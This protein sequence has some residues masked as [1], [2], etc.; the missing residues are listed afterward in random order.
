ML[1]AESGIGKPDVELGLGLVQGEAKGEERDKPMEEG[2]LR[3]QTGG[4]GL[5]RLGGGEQLSILVSRRACSDETRMRVLAGRE[6]GGG[7][8]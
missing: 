4:G 2:S 5:G 3:G 8:K 7:E 6:R 1:F